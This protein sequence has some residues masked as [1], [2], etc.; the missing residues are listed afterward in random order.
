MKRIKGD[1]RGELPEGRFYDP[2]NCLGCGEG[3][4]DR[5]EPP[6]REGGAAEAL[7]PHDPYGEGDNRAPRRMPRSISGKY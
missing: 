4:S 3:W 1:A 7:V 5:K 6:E 2:G